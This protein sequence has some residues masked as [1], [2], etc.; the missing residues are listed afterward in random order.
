MTAPATTVG[1]LR[2]A[3]VVERSGLTYR[4]VDYWVR[5]GLITP[6]RIVR[7]ADG[8][9]SRRLFHPMVLDEIAALR[10]RIRACPFD[11]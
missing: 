9:G 10:S 2:T 3:E 6:A 8:P 11:H 4:Q 1:L 7:K 5:A